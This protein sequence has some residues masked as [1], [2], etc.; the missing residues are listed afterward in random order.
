MFSIFSR[1]SR[2]SCSSESQSSCGRNTN[3]IA[4]R[5]TAEGV[6]PFSEA[7]SLI[8]EKTGLESRTPREPIMVFWCSGLLLFWCY[9]FLAFWYTSFPATEELAH[10]VRSFVF[11][12][13]SKSFP[14]VSHNP[15]ILYLLEHTRKS[16]PHILALGSA[17]RCSGSDCRPVSR[18]EL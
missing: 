4:S 3:S 9:S 17:S 7:R 1:V 5:P 11:S 13:L 6:T 15:V 8:R 2:E 14:P 16:S 12:H 10:K 18:N